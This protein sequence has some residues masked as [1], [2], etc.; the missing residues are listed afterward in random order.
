MEIIHYLHRHQLVIKTDN[1]IIHRIW[2]DSLT[3]DISTIVNDID[4]KMEDWKTVPK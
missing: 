1:W 3:A 4:K 2:L